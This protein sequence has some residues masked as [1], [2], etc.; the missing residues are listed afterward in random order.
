MRAHKMGYQTYRHGRCCQTNSK[1]SQFASKCRALSGT[2]LPPLRE[3]GCSIEFEIV[4][5]VEVSLVVGVVVNRR[6][7][8]CEFLRTSHLPEPEHGPFSGAVRRMRTSG[9]VRPMRTSLSMTLN[10][11]TYAEQSWR[12]SARAAARLSLKLFLL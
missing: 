8:G 11:G 3:S 7:D 12:H 1:Q 6:M 9:G 10:A 2:K 4:S 5:L